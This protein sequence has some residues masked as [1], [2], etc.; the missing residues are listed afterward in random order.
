MGDIG[1]SFSSYT[2]TDISTGFFE[3][4]QEVF[5]S[6]GDKMI[7]KTL[8]IE[9]DII[10]QGYEDHSYDLVV[11]SL[12]LHATTDLQRTL[13]NT[14]RLLK[15]GGYLIIQEVANNGVTRVGF[16]MCALPGWWLGQSDGRKLS[17]CVS[18]L[19]WHRLLLQSG[20][21][22][23]D[24]STPEYDATP[25][26]LAVIVSQAIDDRVALL[27]EPLYSAGIQAAADEE[28]DLVF[29]G[30][31][32]LST[33]QLIEQIIGLVQPSGIRH[34]VFKTLG[35]IDTAKISAK[36]AILCLTELDEPVFKRLTERTLEGLQRLFETQ[37][38]VLW[39]TQ[40][41]R[42]EDPYMNMA[43]GLGRSLVLEN[44]DL[45]LQFLD[46]ESGVKP[47]PRQ[48]LEALLR[49]R[50]SD[51]WEKEGNLD[52]VLWT[53]EHELAYENGD[54][55][56]SR[57]Y[58]NNTLNDRYNAS[59]RTIVETMNP[60]SVPLNLSVGP[61]SKHTL[62]LDNFLAA[63]MLDTQAIMAGSNVL[64]KVSHSLLMPVLAT[65][66]YPSYLVL[67]TSKATEKSVIAISANNGSYALV[68]S[69]KVLDIEL[70]TGQELQF[71]SQLDI[72]LQVENILSICQRDSTLLIHEP[73]PEI[74]SSIVEC[75]SDAN[76]T[77]HFTASSPFP[78]DNLWICIDAYS[79]KRVIQSS[80]PSHVSVFIDCSM[81]NGRTGS[82]I[83]SC[84]PQS[85]L[86]TTVSGIRTL[87]H[88]RS[89]SIA[90]LSQKLSGVAQR[91][92]R[93]VLNPKHT[94]SLP[95]IGLEQLVGQSEIDLTVSAIVDWSAP[96]GVPVQISTVDSQITFK[97]NRTYVLFGLTSDLAQSICDWMA[98]H[99]AR[100]I[101]LTSR[102]PRIEAKWIELLGNTGVRLEV[103]AK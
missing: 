15:P 60:Q 73:S 75:A 19:E 63:E 24:S 9:K 52:N 65:P 92:L 21:S 80:L 88:V 16:L 6:V 57:V 31:Q 40:G 59:K 28:C 49:L 27:R 20:F 37:R 86:Q 39:I 61:S 54:L 81:K 68:S 97:S 102:N 32:S 90:D 29:I 58:Q 42:S 38:T 41:C 17:P 70:P 2:F 11:A 99:G 79:P 87:Q 76:I 45:V 51:I 96:T 94:S 5:A 30:G 47:N 95:L 3:T 36:S 44:P 56:L 82:L 69:E 72:Q 33:I 35:D 13:T 26:P 98:S 43:V 83:A 93:G 77:V 103:F 66:L 22:G 8:D 34:T 4:A 100:N 7:F 23:V 18:T 71:L 84:L 55:T 78:T 1:R 46:L 53:N 50:Q 10:E 12:V 101:V 67:G 14:C 64:I 74:A 48:L 91:A 85:C 25:F 89:F 62:V